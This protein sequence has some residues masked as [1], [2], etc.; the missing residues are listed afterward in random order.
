M[1]IFVFGVPHT[2]TRPEFNTCAFTMKAWNLC[3]MMHNRGHEVIHIGTEGSQP[4]CSQHVSVVPKDMWESLYGHPGTNF[5]NTDTT[6]KFAPLHELYAKNAKQ[7]I[8]DLGGENYTSILACTWGGAQQIACHGTPQFTVESGIGYR[9]T[10]AGYRVFESYAWMHMLAGKDGNFQGDRWYDVVIPNAFDPAMFTRMPKEDYFLFIGRLNDDKGVGIAIDIARKVGTKLKIAGQGDPTRFLRDNPHVEYLG[11]LNIEQRKEAMAKARAGIVAT[12]YVEPFGGTNVELQMCFPADVKVSAS[13]IE[14]L[15]SQLYTGALLQVRTE[16]GTV[17]C[18]P[19]HPFLTQR[20]WVAAKEITTEDSVV[21]RK[22]NAQEVDSERIGDLTARLSK[23]GAYSD[24]KAVGTLTF[25]SSIESEKT[26]AVEGGLSSVY[27]RRSEDYQGTLSNQRI[28]YRR[29]DV[30]TRSCACTEKGQLARR[31]VFGQSASLHGRGSAINPTRL[32]KTGSTQVSKNHESNGAVDRL[33]SV[34]TQI[35]SRVL[36]SSCVSS[37]YDDRSGASLLCRSNRRR[38]YDSLGNDDTS[39][40][41]APKS[42]TNDFSFKYITANDKL[43]ENKIT[44]SDCKSASGTRKSAALLCGVS[45]QLISP[46]LVQS[47]SSVCYCETSAA[48]N[49]HRMVGDTL[50]SDARRAFNSAGDVTLEN[51]PVYEF[52]RVRAVGRREVRDLPVYNLGTRLGIYE[53]GGLVVH[54]CGT[55]VITTD[56]GAFPE[57]VLHGVTGYRCRTQEQFIWAAKNIDKIDPENCRKWAESNFSL[58]RVALMYEEYFQQ[59]LNIKGAGW[60]IAFENRTQL[61]WLRKIYPVES[62]KPVDLTRKHTGPELPS[63]WKDAHEFESCW[64]GLEPNANWD[65]EQVKQLE[66][67]RLMG[68]PTDLDMRDSRILDVGC[69]PISLL[70]RV[71][72]DWAVGIDPLKVSKQT[73]LRY[74]DA[75]MVFMNKKAEDIAEGSE[76]WA[77]LKGMELDE[78]WMYNCLQHVETPFK[79]LALL[80]EMAPTVRIFEWIDLPKHKGHP[81][82]LTQN[83]F[84]LAFPKEQYTRHIWNV[85]FLEDPTHGHTTKYIALHVTRK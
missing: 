19:E 78:S 81:Q 61:D 72:H 4:I 10:F 59:V 54:N 3:R 51:D 58:E 74:A 43:G 23:T 39:R 63:E 29:K 66:Y 77:M 1:R 64:W 68:I 25:A 82:S 85:G 26:K 31:F 22:S 36:R 70:Q 48:R 12:R 65:A 30:R 14:R 67:A 37:S 11:P 20:G 7:A 52:T 80:K 71:K 75:N 35:E 24:G 9:H 28:Q 69:G 8:L 16:Q 55:P 33:Q 42:E 79:V 84:E 50:G 57:T 6:G 62:S 53:A 18:T 38:R 5:Y 73:E 2:Q 76:D 47:T 34:Q 83:M 44:E 40:K 13:G 45:R 41:S 56:W 46:S 32:W 17:E 15:Y 60:P 27:R 21:R 49:D